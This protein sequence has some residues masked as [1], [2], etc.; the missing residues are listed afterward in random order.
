MN[1]LKQRTRLEWLVLHWLCRLLAADKRK[2][3]SGTRAQRDPEEVL[4]RDAQR[5]PAADDRSH[6]GHHEQNA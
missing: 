1:S 5:E 2:S 4:Q 3:A 6:A